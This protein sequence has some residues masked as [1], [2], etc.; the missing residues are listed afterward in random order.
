[1]TDEC[2]FDRNLYPS[3]DK[4]REDVIDASLFERAGGDTFVDSLEYQYLRRVRYC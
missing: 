1:M 3:L 2:C 4:D